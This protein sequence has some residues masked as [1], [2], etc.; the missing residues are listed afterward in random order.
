[1]K[2]YRC[3]VCEWVYDPE[4]GD[5]EG[6]IPPGTDFETLPDRFNWVCP[7]CGEGREMFEPIDDE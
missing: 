4:I 1:M 3:S 6:G 5:P 7:V 2:K